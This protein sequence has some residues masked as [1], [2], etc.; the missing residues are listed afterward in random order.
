MY[1]IIPNWIAL[2]HR[3]G[4]FSTTRQGGVSRMPYDDG[5]DGGGLNLGSHVDDQLVDVESNRALL[6]C[7][8]PTSP[9]WLSQVHG[10]NVVDAAEVRVGVE[11][12]AAI[13]TKR[14]VVCAVLTA[15]CLP[16]LFYDDAGHVVGAAHAGWR[17][18][19]SGVLE[20]TVAR[21][22]ASG[23]EVGEI[24]AWCG[25]AIGPQQ[26]EVGTDVLEAFMAR[27]TAL[28]MSAAV[29]SEIQSAF[30][31][32]PERTGK[33]LA[34]IYRLARIVLREVNVHH[35]YGGEDCT[36]SDKRFYSYRRDKVTGRMAAL[37]WLK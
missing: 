19:V 23:D 17:G 5:M 1:V 20:N 15:D 37:I 31:A 26:F 16:V 14:G 4:A 18:L 21:M 25:P 28:Q 32:I 35:V 24:V 11:A 29:Q 7:L 3:V 10:V 36:V 8:L 34:D 13:T 22:R 6:D 9:I 2:P 12:D 27:A 33:Y 30:F